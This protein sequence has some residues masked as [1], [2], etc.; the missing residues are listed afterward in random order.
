MAGKTPNLAALLSGM[1][2]TE[3]GDAPG[4]DAPPPDLDVASQEVLASIEAKNPSRL[5]EAL[6]AFLHLAQGT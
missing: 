1:G 4:D 5:K 6:T 3:G 2:P